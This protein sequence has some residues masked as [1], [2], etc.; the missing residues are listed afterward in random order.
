MHSFTSNDASE[1]APEETTFQFPQKKGG[2]R[3]AAG[4]V[5]DRIN[6]VKVCMEKREHFYVLLLLTTDCDCCLAITTTARKV[7]LFLKEER[8][9]YRQTGHKK[10]YHSPR[11]GS[12]YPTLIKPFKWL[13]IKE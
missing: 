9:N 1:S 4:G 7:V 6:A 10:Y 2:E 8:K 5:V 11:L 13:V 3:R 12:S